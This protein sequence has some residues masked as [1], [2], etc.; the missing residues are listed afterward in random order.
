MRARR[1]TFLKLHSQI[2]YKQQKRRDYRDSKSKILQTTSKP[3]DVSM[4]SVLTSQT[5]R[6]FQVM[7]K[8]YFLLYNDNIILQQNDPTLNEKILLARW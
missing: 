1:V 8:N 5:E 2:L 3:E 6:C 4:I 7:K